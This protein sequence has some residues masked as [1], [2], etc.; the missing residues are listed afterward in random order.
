[1]LPQGDLIYPGTL[2]AVE[3]EFSA[4]EGSYEENGNIRAA[5]A[6]K[7]FYDMISRRS[8]VLPSKKTLYTSLKKAKYVYGIVTSIKEET[9]NISINSIEDTFISPIS[10]I[11]HVTQ[12][13]NKYIKNITDAIKI[14]DIIKAKP[15][16][17]TIP[18]FLTLKGK[19][20]GVILAQCSICG[21][22]MIKSDEEHL[23]CPNC[24]NIEQR[25]IGSYMVKK[26][27]N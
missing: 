11:L 24:G 10:G 13:S 3:E 2:L 19:D 21:H 5:V 27:A 8:N 1:M 4:G 9:A 20:L 14:G 6:G 25:K 12:I 26:I 16:T 18:V 17:F 7:V 23:K 15:I 22:I